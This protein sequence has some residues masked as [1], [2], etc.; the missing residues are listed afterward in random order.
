M[1][2]TPRLEEEKPTLI[3]ICLLG[4]TRSGSTLFQRALE[5]CSNGV[6]IGELIRL[7]TLLAEGRTC[8]CGTP[9]H[10]CNFWAPALPFL[11]GIEPVKER[12]Q[13]TERLKHARSLGAAVLG[14]PFIASPSDRA[15][16]AALRQGLTKLSN[17]TESPVLI[18]SSKDPLQFLRI[19]LGSFCRVLPVHL[20]RDPRGVAWSALNRTGTDPL[21]MAKHWKRL[22]RAILLLRRATPRYPWQL[23]RYEDFCQS[24]IATVNRVL[25]AAGRKPG[26]SSP[27]R[28]SHA[29]GGS[30]GFSLNQINSIIFDDRWK[31]EMPK[32]L[33]LQIMQQVGSCSRRFAYT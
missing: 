7:P 25:A 22:N 8:A 15:S 24:P 10:E 13:W 1:R 18:D 17:G 6:A 16:A 21:L 14:L 19:A 12:A 29:L 23:V 9:I 27:L 20:V 3:L 26:V 11:S 31:V 4:T 30:P 2:N 32:A 28:S 5:L 33:Q